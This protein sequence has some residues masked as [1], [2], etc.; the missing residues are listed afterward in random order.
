MYIQCTK[1]LLILILYVYD[2]I[3]IHPV[4]NLFRVPRRQSMRI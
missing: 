4:F 1:Y 3:P 2:K